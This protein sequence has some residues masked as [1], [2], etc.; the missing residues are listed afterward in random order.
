MEHS[1]IIRPCTE[2]DFNGVVPLLRQL[3]PDQK[4]DISALK[5]VF[6]HNCKSENHRYLCVERESSLI[7]FASLL[8]KKNLWVQGNLGHIEEMIVDQHHRNSG[9]GKALLI[10]VIECAENH[11]CKKIELESSHHRTEAHVFY[12][13]IGFTDRALWFSKG[14]V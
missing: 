12:R 3:W 14:I 9:I 11:G 8:I 7:G 2:R 5:S 13:T 1:I 10:K 4:P 6:E